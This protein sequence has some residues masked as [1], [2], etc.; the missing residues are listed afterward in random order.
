MWKE[1]WSFLK[2]EF[3]SELR[4]KNTLY[5]ILLYLIS[6][7]Y[8]SYLAFMKL[9]NDT[10]AALF[11]IVLMFGATN[12]VSKSFIHNT[13]GKLLYTASLISP[14]A[15][16]LAKIIYNSLLL[17]VLSIISVTFFGLLLGL[18]IQNIALFLIAL[19]LGCI[20]IAGSLTM[21]SA[22]SFRAT[23]QIALMAVLS[24]PLL[25][26]ILSME[27]KITK[28]CIDGI[29]GTLVTKNILTICSIDAIMMA[30]AYLL[31]PYLWRE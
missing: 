19:I 28:L 22:I 17:S 3:K 1:I 2:F 31:F 23:N 26:P 25:L 6:S 20:G 8:V 27:L 15:L 7:V 10:W 14:Q 30:L 5:G 24:F 13:S 4:G 9:E 18:P 16:I 11:W 12:A 21:T 29:V